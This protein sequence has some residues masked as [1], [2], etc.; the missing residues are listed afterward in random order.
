LFD[1][2]F[3]NKYA[4]TALH[5]AARAHKS[6]DGASAAMVALLLEHG[7]YPNP[8]D[9]QGH[10]PLDYCDPAD[11]DDV[12]TVLRSFGAREGRPGFGRRVR[13]K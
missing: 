6:H 5:L 3:A 13:N 1:L 10:T 12:A 4:Q 7:A 9:D 11:A 8:R 2:N